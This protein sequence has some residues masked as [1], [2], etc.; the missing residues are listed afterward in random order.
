MALS[1]CSMHTTKVPLR[2]VPGYPGYPVPGYPVGY[3]TTNCFNHECASRQY[4]VASISCVMLWNTCT[5]Q[6][7]GKQG[8]PGRN[9]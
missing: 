3:K 5:L 2:R 4:Q 8:R 1:T 7:P 6:A 9:S